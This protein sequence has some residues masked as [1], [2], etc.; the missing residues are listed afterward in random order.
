MKSEINF[1]PHTKVGVLGG[2]QLGKMMAIAAADW[3]LPL[4]LLDKEKGYPAG[5]LSP[6]FQVGN[7]KNYDD[8]YAFGQGLDVLTIEI[9]HVNTE[10]LHQLE[11]EGLTVHPA[12][13]I[14]D[15]IKDKGL[16]KLFYQ[17]YDIPSSPFQLHDDEQAL[18]ASIE[19]GEVQFPF[20]QKSRT[21]G[22]DGKGVSVIK[23]ATDLPKL[24]KGACLTEQLVDID[25]ELAVVV[26]R[27]A[28]GETC[29]YPAVEMAFH[30]EANLVEFLFCPA[31]T[32]SQV[33]TAAR[34]LALRVV[35]AFGVCGLLAVELFLDTSGQLLVNE[36]APRPHNSGHHTINSSHT[37]QFEQHIRAIN[38]LPLGDTGLIAPAVMVNLLGAEG[39]T[40]PARYE[41]LAECLQIPGA[42]LHLYGKST[43]K[44]FR[45]MGHATVVDKDLERAKRNARKLQQTLKIISG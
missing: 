22:Y 2:G 32:T 37:S 15:T 16:Q 35:N 20:V 18:L 6:H 12:P 26:A 13:A 7:F 5:F 41:N 24:L 14:L 44:P 43:T 33:E 28:N 9:E 4:H 39:H 29:A 19:A 25:K 21:A 1:G 45:K 23:N 3:H 42:H 17:E 11:K 27:N 31:E 34:E 30:P 10:A 40:G 38:N 36:V 8:V